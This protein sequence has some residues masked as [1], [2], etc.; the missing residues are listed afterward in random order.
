MHR[1]MGRPRGPHKHHLLY[2]YFFGYSGS[3]L[4]HAGLSSHSAWGFLN[5]ARRLGCPAVYGSLVP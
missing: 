5:E 3:S 1:I 4:R 2:F